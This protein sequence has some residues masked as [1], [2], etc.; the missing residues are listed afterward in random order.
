M[1]FYPDGN[2]GL[3]QTIV[4]D[5]MDSTMM[6]T[7]W[8]ITQVDGA[9]SRKRDF[10]DA[11]ITEVQIPKLDQASKEANPLYCT[12]VTEGMSALYEG[13]QT[14]RPKQKKWLTS[15]FRL[16]LGDLPCSR[17]SKI[18]SFTVKQTFAE[19]AVGGVQRTT[20]MSDV[21]FE[22]P[23]ED[24]APFMEWFQMERQGTG[25]ALPFEFDLYDGDHYVIGVRAM[26]N[27]VSLGAADMFDAALLG[28]SGPTLK[29]KGSVFGK[30]R[31]LKGHVT[32]IK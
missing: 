23:W 20:I 1:E 26:L 19:D 13:T 32:L 15:N 7:N 10:K 28:P 21:S 18:D 29:I 14:Q 27:A 8:T 6:G 12:A 22:V 11:L 31:E 30:S 9:T 24:A 25:V 17:V 2:D 16:K 4:N 3:L 5:M